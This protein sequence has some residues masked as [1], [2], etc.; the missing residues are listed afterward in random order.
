MKKVLGLG[1]ALVDIMTQVK[2]DDFLAKM[3]LPKGSMQL[4]DNERAEYIYKN[5]SEFKRDL[6]SG[7]S[8][9]NTING[10]SNL[11]IDTG[12][13]GKI[14]KDEM[15]IFYKNDLLKNKVKPFL[16]EGKQA[17]GKAMA[18]VT[19]DGE[20]TF[21]T[22]LGAAIEL[23]KEDISENWFEGFD[24]FHI[25]GYLVQNNEL[26]E[27]ALRLAKRKGLKTS[28]DLASYNVV[29]ENLDF[30][31]RIVSE[32]VDIVFA[33][34]EEAFA[35]TGKKPQQALEELALLCE[36]AIVKVGKEG[37]LI[38][39]GEEIVKV[40]AIPARVID[41]T[42]AGDFYAAGFLF[43]QAIDMDL[44]RSGKYGAI[45]AGNVIEYI[46]ANIPESKWL[47]IRKIISDIE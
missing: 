16:L 35:F 26:I 42:G 32:Y 43:G 23:T 2:S 27:E 1:N 18:L 11:L 30:L 37:A 41:T 36:I 4:V 24:Y 29:E 34:E 12:F 5:T 28:L 14:G 19:P 8:A 13:I 10:L 40:E 25:E 9:A 31:K 17:T 39:K 6:A 7:G 20:R 45:L 46:G 33:N 15:G 47:E 38:K 22:F 44:E 3:E 21:G